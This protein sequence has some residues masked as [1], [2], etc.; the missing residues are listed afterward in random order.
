M[1][2]GCATALKPEDIP[3]VKQGEWIRLPPNTV[4]IAPAWYTNQPI[5]VTNA[6]GGTYM[7]DRAFLLILKRKVEQDWK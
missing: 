3:N 6:S 7:S 5:T 4:I 2:S 1:L